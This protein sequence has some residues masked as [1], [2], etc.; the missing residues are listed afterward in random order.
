MRLTASYIPIFVARIGSGA[1]A[2]LVVKL[3]SGG[4]LEAGIE[5]GLPK[6]G[7]G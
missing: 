2:F 5:D 4:N 7:D 3:A 1:S 6:L